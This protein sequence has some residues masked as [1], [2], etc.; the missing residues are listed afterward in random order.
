MNVVLN[1]ETNAYELDGDFAVQCVSID[2]GC[3]DHVHDYIE[4]AYCIPTH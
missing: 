4:M 1:K 2:F 3:K